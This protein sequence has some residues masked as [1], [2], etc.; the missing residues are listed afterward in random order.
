MGENFDDVSVE[1]LQHLILTSGTL[2][3][4]L[5]GFTEHASTVLEG[6]V[7]VLCGVTVKREHHAATVASSS[8]E[9]I[10][11]DEVQY[12][13]GEGPSLRAIRTG[14]TTVVTDARTDTRWPEHPQA[15]RGATVPSRPRS[16][17]PCPGRSR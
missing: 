1:A 7:E 2:E 6:T 13:N 16:R 15:A 12:G 9:A 14:T 17:S 3:L 11:L 5:E 8:F 10:A 4:F